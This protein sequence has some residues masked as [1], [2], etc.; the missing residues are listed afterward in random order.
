M[1]LNPEFTQSEQVHFYFKIIIM[2]V[3]DTGCICDA[4]F[5]CPALGFVIHPDTCLDEGIVQ[6]IVF[7]IRGKGEPVR[8]P[9]TQIRGK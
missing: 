9:H 7:V 6:E 1:G 4:A 5:K 8:R 2:R 3:V